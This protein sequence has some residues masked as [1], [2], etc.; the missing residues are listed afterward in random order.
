MS[1]AGSNPAVP[2]NF[3]NC[4]MIRFLMVVLIATSLAGCFRTVTGI[5]YDT[6]TL[7]IEMGHVV[8]KRVF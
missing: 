2:T 7:P 6:A 1:V 3:R 8:L 5:A 4:K